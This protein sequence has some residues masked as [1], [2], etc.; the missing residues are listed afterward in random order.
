MFLFQLGRCL[1]GREYQNA[2]NPLIGN[3]K[4]ETL[5]KG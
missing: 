5:E 4:A 2:K 3:N 1:L